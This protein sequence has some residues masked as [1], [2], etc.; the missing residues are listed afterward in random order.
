MPETMKLF[1]SIENE[2]TTY[3]HGKNV[4]HLKNTEVM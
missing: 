3:K 1:G 2:I 4:P